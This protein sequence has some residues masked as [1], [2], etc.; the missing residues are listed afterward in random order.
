MAT[1]EQ[2]FQNAEMYM[3][4]YNHLFKD[5]ECN[6]SLKHFKAMSLQQGD[7]N[8]TVWIERWHNRYHDMIKTPGTD[9]HNVL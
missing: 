8:P 4:L 9:I 7:F 5:D 1:T 3:S 6:V 2:K